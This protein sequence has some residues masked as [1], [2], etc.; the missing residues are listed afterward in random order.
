MRCLGYLASSVTEVKNLFVHDRLL[1]GEGEEEGGTCLGAVLV[2]ILKVH[3]FS[4]NSK[5]QF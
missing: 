5:L 2:Q 4:Q 3:F 1:C